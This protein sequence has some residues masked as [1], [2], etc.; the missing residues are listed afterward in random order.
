MRA[1]TNKVSR[2]SRSGFYY[3]IN[4]VAPINH[5]LKAEFDAIGSVIV[6][7]LL[8]GVVALVRMVLGSV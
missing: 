6:V 8:M 7:S 1:K 2:V 5:L 3:L 4:T